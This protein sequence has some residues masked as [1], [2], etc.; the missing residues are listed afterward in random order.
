M[1]KLKILW[2]NWRCIKNPLAGGAEVYTHEIAKRL[3]KRGHEIFLITSNPGNLLALEKINGY[4]VIRG[5][6]QFSVYFKAYDIYR[7]LKKSGWRPDLI[8]D[9]INTIPFFTILYAKEP[10]V[11][12]IHQLC[13]ECWK[14]GLHSLVEKPGWFFEKCVHKLYV[15]AMKKGLVKCAITVSESTKDDLIKLGY[16][17]SKIF[18]VYNGLSEKYC[19]NG[20]IANRK[21]CEREPLVL[22]L[23]R[24]TPYKKIEDII[25]CWRI[26][27]RKL[28]NARLIIAGRPEPAYLSKLKLIAKRIGV[29]NI[30]FRLNLSNEDKEKLL[31][32]TKLLVYTS[33]REGWGRT[34][35]EAAV[36]GV[37]TV[38]YNVPGLG[39][40][41]KNMKTGI[42][43]PFGDINA[44]AEAIMNLLIDE[45]LR[46]KLA[47]NAYMYA[48][49]FI[50]EKS[51]DV[52]EKILVSIVNNSV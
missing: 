19:K 52:F 34:V 41:V 28:P 36:F 32:K 4:K 43:V 33:V 37:P 47:R 15:Y 3:S 45:E 8:I 10:I 16:S 23:G 25:F 9:E 30:E 35:L 2:Y 6:N 12:L 50:W 48:K 40:A 39:E 1:D 21:N 27:E 31:L 7:M 38:A 20:S 29:K 26:V 18:I 51:V 49:S 13:K 24:I 11:V 14:Y 17:P 42:L 22:Y 5:G 46:T 44:L